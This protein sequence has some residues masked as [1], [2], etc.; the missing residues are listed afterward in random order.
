MKYSHTI[1]TIILAIMMTCCK[2]ETKVETISLDPTELTIAIGEERQIELTINPLSATKYNTKFW[3]SSDK[4]VATVDNKGNVTGIYAGTCTITATVGDKKAKCTVTVKTPTYKIQMDNAIIFDNGFDETTGTNIR[5]LR[6][7]EK[8]LTIDSTG[9]ASG[10]GMI[11]NLHLFSPTTTDTLATGLYQI[12]ESGNEFTIKP[13]NLVTSDEGTYATGSFLGEYSDYGISV[14]FAVKGNVRIS[15]ENEIFSIQCSLEG[16]K[17]EHMDIQWQ[18]K[19]TI[20]K[21]DS[22][23]EITEL[24]YK[25]LETEEIATDSKTKHVKVRFDCTEYKLN[26]L[27]RVPLSAHDGIPDG[28]YKSD[29]SDNSFTISAEESELLNGSVTTKIKQIA[30]KVANGNFEGS[31]TDFNGRIFAIKKHK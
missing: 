6:L 1:F 17:D 19:P 18:G 13:G 27:F 12:D 30:M 4:N 5:I 26:V 25:S 8:G 11:M 21:T 22:A 28:Q 2:D 3:S 20:F 24:T 10:N 7:Y 14:L 9:E 15:K 29:K 31:F 16:E 23:I